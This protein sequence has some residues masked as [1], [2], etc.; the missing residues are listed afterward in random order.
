MRFSQRIGQTPVNK[1]I[2]LEYV[3]EEL[4]NG[5]WNLVKMLFI[6]KLAKYADYGKSDFDKFSEILWHNF[7]KMPIDT[8]PEYKSSVEKY[9]RE[10]F[11]N[12]YWYEIYDFL[13]FIIEIQNNQGEK[14][15]FINSVNGILER[16]FAGYRII[17]EKV[18]PISNQL[19]FEEVSFALDKTKFL[20][21]LEGANIHLTNAIDLI[22]DKKNPNYRNSV[23]ESISAVEST[24]R[25][26]TGENT[27]GKALNK[28]ESK[29]LN[30]NN[31]LKSG[32]DKIYAYTNDKDNGIRHAIVT[33]PIEPDFADAKYMLISCSSFINYLIT[34][35]EKIGIKFE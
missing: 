32:F 31:Q 30:L 18:A 3:D 16:E 8:I 22:S 21:A 24:C 35:A 17:N 2:Q 25:I 29:G 26:I 34:K 15:K 27:L 12:F 23:K 11:F 20:T 9:I 6:D 33:A 7:Y 28:L 13:E 4:T 5:L 1:E 10:R 19:E 14:N